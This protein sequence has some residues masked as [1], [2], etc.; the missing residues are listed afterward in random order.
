VIFACKTNGYADG[1]DEP[2]MAE[3]SCAAGGDERNVEKIGLTE[4]Q[5]QTSDRQNRDRQHERA[6]ELLEAG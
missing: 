5:E 6:A 1:E 2:E 3:Y 4:P